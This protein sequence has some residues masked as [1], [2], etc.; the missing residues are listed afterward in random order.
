MTLWCFILLKC[1]IVDYFILLYNY[2]LFS[3]VFIIIFLF[4]FRSLICLTFTFK[5]LFDLELHLLFY[6]VFV[7][8]YLLSFYQY[9]SRTIF[10]SKNCKVRTNNSILFFPSRHIRK[11]VLIFLKLLFF[12]ETCFKFYLNDKTPLKT[13]QNF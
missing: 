4:Y 6:L 8:W 2:Y 13:L 1:I 11:H 12:K 3:I 9:L 5:I 10:W 7:L